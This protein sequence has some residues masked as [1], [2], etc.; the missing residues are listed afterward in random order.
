MQVLLASAAALVNIATDGAARGRP[1]R[2]PRGGELGAALAEALGLPAGQ[3]LAEGEIARLGRT[4]EALREVFEALAGGRTDDAAEA[5]NALLDANGARPQLDKFETEGGTGEWRVHF[6]GRDDSFAVG[7]S[8]GCATGVA[9][10]LGGGLAGRLGV[11]AA[12]GCDRVYADASRN[13][14]RQF[15]STACQNRTKAAAFRARQAR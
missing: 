9:M 2:A 11:C 12:T 1:Y 5:L 6:H 14:A 8:A 4:A 3:V 7:W 13:A 15:C 10:V